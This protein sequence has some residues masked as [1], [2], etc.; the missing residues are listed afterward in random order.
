MT[1]KTA[2][3][4]A[5]YAI[6][7]SADRREVQ[8]PHGITVKVRDDWDLLFPAELPADA[9]DPLLSDDLNLMGLLGEA[10]NS[11]GDIGTGA[12]VDLVFRN[13]NLPGQLIAAVKEIYKALLGEDEFEDFK[14]HKPSV[15]EYV[16][17]TKALATIY[18]VDLGKLFGL[19][20][21]SAS[22]SQTSS[23]TSPATTASTPDESGSDQDS[24]DSSDSGD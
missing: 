18:A 3:T 12:I 17:L 7:I 10:M 2:K 20:G 19:G 13:G 15:P 9:L 23:P 8:F 11:S 4:D 24:P 1:A 16:R 22:D 21:S 14:A 5:T 6:D